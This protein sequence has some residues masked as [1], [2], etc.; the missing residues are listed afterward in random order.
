MP[1]RTHHVA[2]RLVGLALVGVGLIGLLDAATSSVVARSLQ[3]GWA[4]LLVPAGLGL[5]RG[6]AAWALPL[7][8][9]MQ[10]WAVVA[11]GVVVLAAFA[12]RVPFLA[13]GVEVGAWGRALVVVT[14]VVEAALWVWVLGLGR[15]LAALHLKRGAAPAV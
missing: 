7:L 3:V 4:V 11:A 15:R 9:V 14:A 10:V 8:R 2:V 6:N 5:A 12:P 13:D 1:E